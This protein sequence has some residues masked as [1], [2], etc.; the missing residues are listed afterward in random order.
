MIFVLNAINKCNRITYLDEYLYFY[1]KDMNTN[2][3]SKGNFDYKKMTNL[4]AYNHA[5]TLVQ[6]KMQKYVLK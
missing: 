5:I 2:S 6:R 3:L 4:D 1:W